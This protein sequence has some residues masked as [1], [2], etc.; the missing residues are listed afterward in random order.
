M[1]HVNLLAGYIQYLEGKFDESKRTL[2]AL[3]EMFDHRQPNI[4]R[5]GALLYRHLG[6]IY[7]SDLARAH[8]QFV[9][10]LRAARRF[11]LLRSTYAG[12]FAQIGAMLEVNCLRVAE[13]RASPWRLK[14][15]LHILDSA[16]PLVAGASSRI[17]AYAADTRGEPEQ[18]LEWLDRAEREACRYG[19]RI[20][21]AIAKYQRGR[22]LGGD[23]GRELCAVARTMVVE[24]G[25]SPALL[26]EDAGS[27]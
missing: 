19:R 1:A 21:A 4:Q 15:F 8:V 10:A 9:A 18:A 11:G 2:T 17:K 7:L 13:G 24:L 3:A 20:D 14:R 23:E 6:D 5:A 16:P 26:D 25:A 12:P 22:R 27:R